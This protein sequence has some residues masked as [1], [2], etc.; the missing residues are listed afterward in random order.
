R[1]PSGMSGDY[2]HPA[3]EHQDQNRHASG[4]I[5]DTSPVTGS[6]SGSSA[7]AR[8]AAQQNIVESSFQL[9]DC[10]RLV[11]NPVSSP[12]F[13][14]RHRGCNNPLNG[15]SSVQNEVGNKG[16]AIIA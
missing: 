16:S 3:S 12:S 9:P 8:T 4:S 15:A 1:Y 14:Q 5:P 11:T 13:S 2:V 10:G 6:L 7:S